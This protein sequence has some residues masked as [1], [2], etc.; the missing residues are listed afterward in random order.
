VN[1]NRLLG[2]LLVVLCGCISVP[3]PPVRAKLD[4]KSGS[5]VSLLPGPLGLLTSA[6][7]GA[8]AAAFAYLGPFEID[9]MG[10]RT[11]FLW[12][13]AP[14]DVPVS[15]PPVIQ[16]DGKVFN[17]PVQTGSLSKMGLTESPYE[18]PYPWGTQWYFALTDAALAC[19][20]QAHLIALEIPEPG[21]EPARFR[22]ESAKKTLGFPVLQAFVAHRGD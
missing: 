19:L 2:V 1:Y 15:S 21:G 11:L 9:R 17:L 16:C 8:G 6:Y 10:V 7:R 5:T 14:N 18:P 4:A 22:I 20:A 3:N 12:V 13:L